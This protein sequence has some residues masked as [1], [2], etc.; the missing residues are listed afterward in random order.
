VRALSRAHPLA[1]GG[2]GVTADPE[3]SQSRTL[4]SDPVVAAHALTADV[5]RRERRGDDGRGAS[6]TAG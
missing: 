1:L 2:A 5:Q 4:P 3:W 6:S